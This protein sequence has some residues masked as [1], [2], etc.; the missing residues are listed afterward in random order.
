MLLFADRGEGLQRARVRDRVARHLH[1]PTARVGRAV[2]RVPLAGHVGAAKDVGAAAV[3]C[4]RQL[5]VELAHLDA[6]PHVQAQEVPRLLLVQDQLR[7]G[8]RE[9]AIGADRPHG[10]LQP[11]EVVVVEVLGVRGRET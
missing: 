11:G 2:G 3:V 5:A 6:L 8:P 10:A 7:V 9:G 4:G 1:V